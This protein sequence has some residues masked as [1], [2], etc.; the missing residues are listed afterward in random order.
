[1]HFKYITFLLRYI[2]WFPLLR[3]TVTK[4]FPSS[5]V[6]L[7]RRSGTRA[8]GVKG[9]WRRS[10]A[11]S[12]STPRS[13]F[14][15]LQSHW[16]AKLS[17]ANQNQRLQSERLNRRLALDATRFYQRPASEGRPAGLNQQLTTA[18][19]VCT[20]QSYKL[21][22]QMM[23]TALLWSQVS[24]LRIRLKCNKLLQLLHQSI[25]SE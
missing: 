8:C 2:V 25:R 13:G 9:R 14:R 21:L 15:N 24:N 20:A 17:F 19:C 7:I 18:L 11:F 12:S 23:Q 6:K 5:S 3:V 10:A 22:T 1:M 4:V 16:N